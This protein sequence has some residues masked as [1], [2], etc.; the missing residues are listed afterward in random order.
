MR[1]TLLSFQSKI[2]V[3][4]LLI[5]L[6]IGTYISGEIEI[7]SENHWRLFHCIFGCLFVIFILLHVVQHW[8]F[9]KALLRKRVFAKNKLTA[10]T[11]LLFI[12]VFLNI[13]TLIVPSNQLFL[14]L[15]NLFGQSFCIIAIVHTIQKWKR[16]TALFLSEKS[17]SR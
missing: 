12:I 17:N 8:R 6:L 15:H 1:N 14:E 11:T 10:F 4:I 9:V 2:I 13:V 16:F 7:I 3:D 5:L